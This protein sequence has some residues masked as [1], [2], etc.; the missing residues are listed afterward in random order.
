MVERGKNRKNRF[1]KKYKDK[2][3]GLKLVIS[4][5]IIYLCGFLYMEVF[6]NREILGMVLSFG[7]F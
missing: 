5:I 4:L 3:R 7:N 6:K 2:I 1:S